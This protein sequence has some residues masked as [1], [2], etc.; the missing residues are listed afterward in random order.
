VFNAYY[1]TKLSQRRYRTRN[2]DKTYKYKPLGG[3]HD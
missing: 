3:L 2:K 1:F